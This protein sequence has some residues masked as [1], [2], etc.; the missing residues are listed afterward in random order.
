MSLTS[1]LDFLFASTLNLSFPSLSLSL[2]L[3]RINATLL[4]HRP[5]LYEVCSP[6]KILLSHNNEDVDIDLL[7]SNDV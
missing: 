4:C 2:R 5:V 6:C 3:Q 7:G 1:P